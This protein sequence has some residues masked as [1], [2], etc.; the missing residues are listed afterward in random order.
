M[1]EDCYAA[2]FP[3]EGPPPRK[4]QRR[5]GAISI[6]ALTKLLYSTIR[7]PFPNPGSFSVNILSLQRQV[8]KFSLLRRLQVRTGRGKILCR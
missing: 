4:K 1:R 5:R 6:Q 3:A 7:F 8:L 2:I